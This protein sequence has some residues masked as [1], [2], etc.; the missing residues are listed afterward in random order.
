V[1]SEKVV[2][3][4]ALSVFYHPQCQHRSAGGLQQFP[5]AALE[6]VLF[7]VSLTSTLI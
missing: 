2:N 4:R 3:S 6:R 5:S 1:F 7:G